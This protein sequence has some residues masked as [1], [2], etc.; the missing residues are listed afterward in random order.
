LKRV[1][2]SGTLAATEWRPIRPLE[3]GSIY[4]W[5]VTA[6]SGSKKVVAPVP[7]APEAWLKVLDQD[8]AEKLAHVKQAY[9]HSH[10]ALGIL[11]AKAGL[12]DEAEREFH[13]LRI[14]NPKSPIVESLLLSAKALRSPPGR[15]SQIGPSA[16]VA[17]TTRGDR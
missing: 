17:T 9:P 15:L 1:A 8:T 6:R 14:T 16:I 3:R 12:V 10:L 2:A 5:Q 4:S 13:A 11:D 7:P